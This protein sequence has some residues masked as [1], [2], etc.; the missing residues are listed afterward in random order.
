MA[1]FQ[2]IGPMP[3]LDL[4][5]GMSITFEAINA[6]TGAAVSGVTVSSATI[7]VRS[8]LEDLAGS[9]ATVL[10][11]YVAIGDDDSA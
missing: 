8:E 2:L 7:Y 9:E 6:S 11:T 1:D 10:P 4:D 5:T 3:S